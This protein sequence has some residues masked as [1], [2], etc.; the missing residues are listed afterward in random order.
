M[1]SSPDN[2]QESYDASLFLESFQQHTEDL[3]A[4]R[5]EIDCMKG[6][7]YNNRTFGTIDNPYSLEYSP[8]G[9]IQERAAQIRI[10]TDIIV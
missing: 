5:S 3:P 1:E 6:V 10:T 9:M 7:I 2:Q 8:A 4:L